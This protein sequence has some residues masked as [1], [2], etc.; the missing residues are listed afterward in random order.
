[1]TTELKLPE[2]PQPF[3]I[4]GTLKSVYSD[5]QMRAYAREAQRL[6]IE[7]AA[8]VASVEF[9]YLKVAQTIAALME[10]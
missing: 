8:R 1:M 7:E 4:Y 9:G 10:R 6:A 5:N 2:L 3:H